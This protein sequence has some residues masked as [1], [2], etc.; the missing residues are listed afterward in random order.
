MKKSL[1]YPFHELTCALPCLC[2]SI[3]TVIYIKRTITLLKQKELYNIG[4]GRCCHIYY[5]LLFILLPFW[6][7]T[8]KITINFQIIC[9]EDKQACICFILATNI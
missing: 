1:C 7:D 2:T 4:K 9:N 8:F 5:K 3:T 6:Y